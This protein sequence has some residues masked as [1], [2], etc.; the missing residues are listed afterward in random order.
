MP[1]LTWI[2]ALGLYCAG[3]LNFSSSSAGSETC[4]FFFAKKDG[5]LILSVLTIVPVPAEEKQPYSMML[6]PPCLTLGMVIE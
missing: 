2:C 4:F 1:M 3:K 6:P 5:P